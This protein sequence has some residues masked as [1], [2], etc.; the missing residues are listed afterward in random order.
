[1]ILIVTQ[2]LSGF[3]VGAL[4]GLF[5]RGRARQITYKQLYRLDR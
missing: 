1:M 2:L 4:A 3:A 5:L